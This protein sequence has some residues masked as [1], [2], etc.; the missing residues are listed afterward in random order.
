[1]DR[2]GDKVLWDVWDDAGKGR[3]KVIAGTGKFAGCEGTMEFVL[4]NPVKPFP[5]GTIRAVCRESIK[6]TIKGEA[7]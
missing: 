1:V 2:D 3:G 6:V 4:Q 5:E 7:R